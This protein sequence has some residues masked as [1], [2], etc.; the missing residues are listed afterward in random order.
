MTEISR[1]TRKRL[2]QFLPDALQ[3]VLNSYLEFTTA[4]QQPAGADNDS[5]D[6]MGGR[7]TAKEFKEHHDACKVAIAHLELLL[8]LASSLKEDMDETESPEMD[9]CLA[10]ATTEVNVWKTGK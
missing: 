8:D 9:A 10:K 4:P 3:L 5:A 1:E 6:G 7:K 2:A